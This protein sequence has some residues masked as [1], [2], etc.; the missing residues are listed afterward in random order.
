MKKHVGILERAELVTTEKVG[1]ARECRLGS[2]D[3]ADATE[4]MTAYRAAW[5][6]RIDRFGDFVE[7]SG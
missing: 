5:Q 7:R 4:W 2:A 6:G 3:L 1:R